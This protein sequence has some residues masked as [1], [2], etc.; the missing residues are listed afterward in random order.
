MCALRSARADLRRRAARVG[1]RVRAAPGGRADGLRAL[2]GRVKR[3]GDQVMRRDGFS[4]LLTSLSD[5]VVERNFGTGGSWPEAAA[6]LRSGVCPKCGLR[7]AAVAE[8]AAASGAAPEE[9]TAAT[10]SVDSPPHPLGWCVACQAKYKLLD[11]S[12]SF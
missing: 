11:V 1:V 3:A 8:T 2:L 10:S 7:S 12:R 5:G 9:K 4:S 6:A